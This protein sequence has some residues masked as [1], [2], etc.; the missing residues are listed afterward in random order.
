MKPEPYLG[1]HNEP[2]GHGL[3]QNPFPFRSD[4]TES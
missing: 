4:D 3:E 2:D 1:Y